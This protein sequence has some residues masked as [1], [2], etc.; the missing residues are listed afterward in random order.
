MLLFKPI[1]IISIFLLI[2]TVDG[3]TSDFKIEPVQSDYDSLSKVINNLDFGLGLKKFML[4]G[5]KFYQDDSSEERLA[6]FKQFENKTISHI[7]FI[8]MDIFADYK[9]DSLVVT[10]KKD[11]LDETAKDILNSLHINTSENL[12]RRFLNFKEGSKLRPEKILEN[13]VILRKKEFISDCRFLILPDQENSKAV[14]LIVITRDRWPYNLSGSSFNF[15]ERVYSLNNSNV[16]G[17]GDNF[18]IKYYQSNLTKESYFQD[19]YYKMKYLS[20]DF[21]EVGLSFK[22]DSL[23]KDYSFGIYRDFLSI[24]QH[25]LFGYIYKYRAV[26]KKTKSGYYPRNLDNHDVWWGRTIFK[27]KSLN[28]LG[29]VRYYYQENNEYLAD[30]YDED[31]LEQRIMS[32]SLIDKSFVQDININDNGRTEDLETGVKFEIVLGQEKSFKRDKLYFQYSSE[33]FRNYAENYFG[34][35][36]LSGFYARN[37][38]A[39]RI[40]LACKSD[41]ISKLFDFPRLK[42]SSRFLLKLKYI[43]GYRRLDYEEIRFKNNLIRERKK[44]NYLSG[45][46]LLSF[47]AENR[48]FP[49]FSHLGFRF[50]FYSFFDGYLFGKK[51]SFTSLDDSFVKVFGLGVKIFNDMLILKSVSIRFCYIQGSYHDLDSEFI[52]KRDTCFK[53]DYLNFGKPGFFKYE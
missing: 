44:V 7:Y 38:E 1:I 42:F 28:V 25:T 40:T 17:F 21:L 27:D 51:A 14:N 2:F 26:K 48:I 52:L 30:L 32:L 19:V 41:C 53:S 13:E 34:L 31:R 50:S 20:K 47:S 16:F 46:Q 33:I 49:R 11:N 37:F 4:R 9:L 39:S 35:K 36:F 5:R 18:G 24:Y 22:Q 15:D 12:L 43:N 45:R 29:A 8:S 3:H 10:Q 6:H 23:K